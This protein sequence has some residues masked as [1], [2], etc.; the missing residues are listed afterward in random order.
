MLIVFAG[1]AAGHTPGVKEF[2]L[3]LAIAVAVDATLIRRILVPATMTLLGKT[4]WWPPAAPPPPRIG[5]HEALAHPA[6]HPRPPAPRP[7]A[8]AS[9]HGSPRRGRQTSQRAEKE[10]LLLVR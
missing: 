7:P 6:T 4:N 9:P 5:L 1:F 3:A 8:I 2:G 10:D